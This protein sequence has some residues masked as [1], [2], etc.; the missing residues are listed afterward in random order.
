MIEGSKN[1]KRQTANVKSPILVTTNYFSGAPAIGLSEKQLQV[2][3][4]RASVR[5]G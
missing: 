3:G 4:S 2:A 5:G 1:V